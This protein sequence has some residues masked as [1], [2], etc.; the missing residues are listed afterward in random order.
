MFLAVDGDILLY[1]AASAAETEIDWGEDIWSLYT[2]L[3]DAKSSFQHQLDSI[4]TKLGIGDFVVCLSDHGANFRKTV[5]PTYKGNRKGTRKPVGYVALCSW[6]E[7]AFKTFRKPTLE[8][9]DCMGILAT[10]PINKNKCVV[11]SD[12]KDL[13]SNPSRLYRP[14]TDEQL[15]ISEADADRFFLTQVL[16]G[17]QSDGYP[18]VKGVGPKTAEKILGTHPHWGAVE[19]AFIKAGMTRDD[20]IQQARL[21]RILRW[22][23]W[24]EKKGE[25]ILWNPSTY[26]TKTT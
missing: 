22:S 11:V 24:N 25:P 20:A 19:Q 13:K 26:D 17:D 3:N 14:S 1:R 5:D 18:G 16:C 15:E 7:T 6:A 23:D 8:A 12:D 21:A 2:D 9:D 4:T 10:M